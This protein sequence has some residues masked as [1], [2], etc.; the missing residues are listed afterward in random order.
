MKKIKF[1]LLTGKEERLISKDIEATKKVGSTVIPELTTRLRYM[2]KEID[3]E[4]KPEVLNESVQNLLARDS[5]AL[6]SVIT[7]K[8]QAYHQ[9]ISQLLS[10]GDAFL[11]RVREYHHQDGQL[12]EQVNR[13]TGLQQGAKHLTWSYAS[14]IDAI[15]MRRQVLAKLKK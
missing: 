15:L 11:E 14:F 3:G 12:S 5:I 9:I 6:Y 8:H 1:S 13:K 10:Q 4:S 2:I 7:P